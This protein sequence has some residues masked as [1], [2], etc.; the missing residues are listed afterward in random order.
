MFFAT[1]PIDNFIKPHYNT[2]MFHSERFSFKILSVHSIRY[3]PSKRYSPSRSYNALVFRCRG[4]AE[5][6]N[7]K[8]TYRLTQNDVTFI[9]SGYDYMISTLSEEE[10]LVIHFEADIQ[11]G[12]E[13]CNLHSHHPEQ[14]F[15]L[16]HRIFTT[17]NCKP[18]GSVYRLDALFCSILELLEKHTLE[19]HF[20]SPYSNIQRA[21]DEMHAQFSD[22]DFSIE[23]LASFAG[24]CPSYFRRAFKQFTGQTPQEYLIRIRLERARSLLESGY[25]N[26]EQVSILCG[27][28]STKYFSTVYKKFTGNPPSKSIPRLLK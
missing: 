18:I 9:P 4:D 22:H 16:F 20:N 3:L 14:L 25:Y 8:N 17:W 19:S 5:L 28:D 13:F 12:K 24:Y 6:V 1:L 21:I 2:G 26:V 10:V 15:A 27:F 23:K 7:G 11:N